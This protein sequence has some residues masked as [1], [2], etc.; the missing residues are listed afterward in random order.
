MS[1]RAR[2]ACLHAEVRYGTQAWQSD[3]V[4]ARAKPV[5]I[6]R[7]PSLRSGQGFV[8]SLHA[9]TSCLIRVYLNG[10]NEEK[11]G[12]ADHHEGCRPGDRIEERA[13]RMLCHQLLVVDEE[14]H[15]DEHERKDH[16]IDHL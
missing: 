9:M 14:K 2:R 15:E 1:L 5:A 12:E 8:V 10:S 16:P 3:E 11:E 4:V 13:V 6:S 7:V